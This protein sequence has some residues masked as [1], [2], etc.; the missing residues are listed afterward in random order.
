MTPPIN[1]PKEVTQLLAA[2]NAG[3]QQALEQLLPLVYD[4]LRRLADH[5]LRRERSDH[6]LQA[7]ALVHEAYLRLVDQ[8]AAWQN[9][10]HFFGVAA[11]MMR[12]ILVDH[13]RHN[14]AAKRGSGGIKISLDEAIDLSD[15]R[16]ADLIA[17]DEALKNLAALDPEKARMVELRYFGGLSNEETAKMMGVSVPTIVRQ[18]RTTKAWLYHELQG[19]GRSEKG[20]GRKA[21]GES[22]E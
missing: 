1:P 4:E 18:W 16:A 5:Y 15:E 19:E 21:K 9:R 20:E 22:E 12:R 3:D 14:L 7:T 8:D 17:L 2:Y 10:A 11:Q 13:A 6:T